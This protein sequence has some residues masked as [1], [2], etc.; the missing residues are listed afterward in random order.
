MQSRTLLYIWMY[1]TL[2]GSFECWPFSFWRQPTK[3]YMEGFPNNTW[4]I[5]VL[6]Q[7]IFL[8]EVK[9]NCIHESHWAQISCC[10]LWGPKN[11]ENY[12]K[13]LFWPTPWKSLLNNALRWLEC[14]RKWAQSSPKTFLVLKA[15]ETINWESKA[16]LHWLEWKLQKCKFLACY[17]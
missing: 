17:L 12:W 5:V 10:Q 1:C 3:E 4:L 11:I 14:V 6:Q 16:E 13:I 7:W 8:T 2:W 9:A 15:S